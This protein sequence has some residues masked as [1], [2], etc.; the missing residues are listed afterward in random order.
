MHRQTVLK[1][2]QVLLP[3]LIEKFFVNRKEFCPFTIYDN[4]GLN[5]RREQ[6]DRCRMEIVSILVVSEYIT[7]REL[8]LEF[9]V[10]IRTVCSDIT[11]LSY[12]NP[13]YTKPGLTEEFLS[14][15]V[16]SRTAIRLHHT[17]R[18]NSKNV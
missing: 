15:T 11:V 9:G 8:A 18:K 5:E 14:W 4:K 1:P 7:S 6:H 2:I 17:S 16:T 3:I 10:C 13:I 12:G